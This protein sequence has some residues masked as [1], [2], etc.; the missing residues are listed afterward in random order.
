MTNTAQIH[1]GYHTVARRY[2]YYFRVVKTIFYERV[3]KILFSTRENNIHL[4]ALP[5]NVLLIIWSEV[6][7][8]EQRTYKSFTSENMENTSVLVY[9]KTPITI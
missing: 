8:N 5:C 4:F 1:R 7:T 9:G 2:E 6:G 3:N